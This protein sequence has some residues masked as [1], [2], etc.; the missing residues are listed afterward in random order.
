MTMK[1][2]A[3]AFIAPLIH[4]L[5]PLITYSPPSRS[6]RGRCWWHLEMD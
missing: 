1:I 4:H 5:Q 6:M 3:S 2:A